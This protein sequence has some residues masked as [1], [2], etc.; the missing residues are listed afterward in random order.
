MDEPAYKVP[1]EVSVPWRDLRDDEA[2][3]PTDRDVSIT[4]IR[5]MAISGNYPWGIVKVE[6]DTDHYGIG[7]TFHGEEALDVVERVSRHVIGQNPL[8]IDRLMELLDQRYT[9]AG[10][11]G[12]AAFTG[13]EIAL[14]D[15]KGKFFEVPVYELLGGKYRDSVRTYCDTHAGESVGAAL[16]GDEKTVY[17]PESYA[18]AAKAVVNDGF[19]ALK[20]DLDVP[21]PGDDTED[22]AARRLSNDAIQHKVD[23][24]DAV[25]EEIRYSIDLGVDLHWNFTVETAIRLGRKLEPY[26][27]AFIEDPVPPNKLEAQQ[28]VT[29]A[30]QTP[31]LTGENIVDVNGFNDLAAAGAFDIAAPDVNKCG[32]LLDVHRI[33]TICDL[34]GIPLAPHNLSSPLGLV[35]G[36]HLGAAIPNFMAIEFRGRDVPWWNDLVTR[37]GGDG[38]ILEAGYVD[39]PEGPGL[40][41]EIDRDLAVEHIT[42]ESTLIF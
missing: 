33:A 8:D 17:T 23:L 6:T 10:Y 36:V 21:V 19:D 2:Q 15:L 37:T 40:G 13:I 18:K 27:L 14:W 42:D 1:D 28:R 3:R 26:D 39:V 12:K 4:N 31:I 29:E 41:I 38:P 25:R 24:I 9:G 5:T 7:E 34:Y 35:A 22:V 11:I 30:L 16:E 32:G 20:F